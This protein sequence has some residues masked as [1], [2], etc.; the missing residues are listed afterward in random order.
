[1]VPLALDEELDAIGLAEFD[2][3]LQK[4]RDC[5]AALARERAVLATRR[6]RL[7][8][9]RAPPTLTQRICEARIGAETE[10]ASSIEP[11]SD[12]PIAVLPSMGGRAR[13]ALSGF[14]GAIAATLLAVVLMRA[15][16]EENMARAIVESHVG[17]LASGRLFDVASADPETIRPWF[18]GRLDVT[19]PVKNLASRGFDLIGARLEYIADKRAAALVYRHH[20]HILTLYVFSTPNAPVASSEAVIELGYAVCRWSRRGITRWVVSDM[21]PRELVEL[22]ELV[23]G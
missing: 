2:L 20:E 14:G 17:A 22:E 19:P 15:L 4:C 10:P 1:M 5:A 8:R 23:D 11:P 12:V 6:S 18:T 21:D 16:P 7:Q 13:M 9:H 3:H